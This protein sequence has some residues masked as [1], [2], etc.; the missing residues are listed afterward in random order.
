MPK[1]YTKL[2]RDNWHWWR[3]ICILH[4]KAAYITF[5]IQVGIY[6][7]LF[8]LLP[9]RLTKALSH[10]KKKRGRFLL[11][12]IAAQQRDERVPGKTLSTAAAT[13]SLLSC[14]TTHRA[15]S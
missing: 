10:I 13:V 2:E 6:L 7:F 3:S 14:G 11:A 5:E 15:A 4:A 8:T 9:A 1:Y 12:P